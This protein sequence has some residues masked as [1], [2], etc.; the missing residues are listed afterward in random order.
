MRIESVYTFVKIAENNCDFSVHKMLGMP[1][2][3]MWSHISDLEKSLGRQLINRKK[4]GLSFTA[5][6]EE[7]I[8]YARQLYQIYEE[9]LT[10]TNQTED[11]QVGGDLIISTTLG[12]LIAW[13]M[14]SIK[15]LYAE[16]PHLRLHITASDFLSKEEENTADILIRPFGDSDN[17][18]KLW[19]IVY[20]H[21]LFASQEYIEKMG[22]PQS[23]EDLLSHR[24]IG[25]GEHKFS[26]FDDINWHLKGQNGLP[27]LKPFLT[28]NSTTAIFDAARHGLGIGSVPIE[29]SKV[30]NYELVRVLPEIIGPTVG[31]YFCVKKSAAGRKLNTINA[32]EE[33]FRKYLKQH[34]I[35]II[36]VPKP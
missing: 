11:S 18:L 26:Y 8:P 12:N 5:A 16:L 27:K 15:K 20:H 21:G 7:F 25:F 28:I 30:Y 34:D 3:T 33:Y 24:I 2:A 31:T 1:R 29:A 19:G 10:S 35:D 36:P 32:F 17:F 13:S 6:G 14:E 9:S 22:L 4:Q 23:A